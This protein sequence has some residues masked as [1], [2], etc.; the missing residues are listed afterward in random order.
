VT[1]LH[2]GETVRLFI[3]L[4]PGPRTREALQA[5]R[6]AWHW[7]PAARPVQ[8][9]RL[10]LTLHFIGAVA[11]S[12]LPEITVSLRLPWR[13]CALAFG[14]DALWPHGV[15][16]LQPTSVPSALHALHAA[17]GGALQRLRLPTEARSFR[18][19]VTLARHAQGS[20][21]PAAPASPLRWPAR[22]YA[23][24]ESRGGA[25]AGYH[26]LQRYP[27]RS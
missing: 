11:R 21:P 5:R 2:A 9:E 16:V 8:S 23:L 3:A 26:V 14:T 25:N 15:A 19:H 13:G 7:S 18:P 12:R 10:H 20:A 1:T 27:C 24:V 22:G 6:D 4:W 17:L